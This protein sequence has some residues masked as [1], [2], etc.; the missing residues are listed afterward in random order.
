MDMELTQRQREIITGSLLGDGSLTKIY[1]NK[2]SAFREAHSMAQLDY[3]QWKHKNL[4]P[5]SL[6]LK[7]EKRSTINGFDKSK[8]S[9]IIDK[10]IKTDFAVMRTYS[11]PEFK[12]LEKIWYLRNH[13][14]DY[15]FDKNNR[16]IKIIP[17]SVVLTPLS[18]MVWFLDDG[19]NL[20][21]GNSQYKSRNA[22]FHTLSF[23]FEECEKLKDQ[24]QQ[25]GFTGCGV[26]SNKEKPEIVIYSS[27]Y[28]KFMQA[29]DELNEVEKMKYKTDMRAYTEPNRKHSAKLTKK[30]ILKIITLHNSGEKQK[31]ISCIFNVSTATICNI[32]NGSSWRDITGL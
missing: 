25:L 21:N 26:R 13:S 31:E 16:R 17:D 6:P 3:I 11:T 15:V 32:V 12:E 19:T 7:I 29:I 27:S 2:S 1:G 24:I 20:Y 28:C 5:L 30:D 10:N 8:N 18:L 9:P 4:E 14:N 22:V 23:K